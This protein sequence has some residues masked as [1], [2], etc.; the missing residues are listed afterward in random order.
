MT[1][2]DSEKVD[3]I[4]VFDTENNSVFVIKNQLWIV[5]LRIFQLFCIPVVSESAFKQFSNV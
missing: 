1:S 2:W 5:K 3:Y 4:G